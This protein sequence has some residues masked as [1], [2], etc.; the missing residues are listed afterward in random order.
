MRFDEI[1]NYS[2]GDITPE[3]ELVVPTKIDVSSKTETITP[4]TEIS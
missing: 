2:D 3:K 1:Q 4:L